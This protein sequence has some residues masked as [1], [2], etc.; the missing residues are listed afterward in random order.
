MGSKKYF[1]L[2]DSYIHIVYVIHVN[3][4]NITHFLKGKREM[5]WRK[6]MFQKGRKTFRKD[7]HLSQKVRVVN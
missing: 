3:L 5:Y 4:Q 6:F 2:K 1:E 7:N